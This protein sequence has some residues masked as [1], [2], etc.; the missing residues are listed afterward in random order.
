M[1][2]P[3][4]AL[5]L[6]PRANLEQYKKRSKDLVKAANSTN[7]SALRE[8]ARSWVESLMKLAKLK[9]TPQLPVGVEAWIDQLE[10]F[11]REEK[12]ATRFS[13][14]KAQFV[15]ARAHG[16]ESWPKLAHHIESLA[17][18]NSA[19]S[20][21]E[22]AAEAIVAG[23]LESLKKL[24]ERN[25]EMA[26]AR[27]G[28]RHRATLLH[29]V[30][31]NGVEGYR[32]KTPKN[33]VQIA[34][35]LLEAGA[36]VNAAAEVY[37][38]KATT[39]ALVATSVHPEQAGLQESLMELLLGR[40]ASIEPG[41]VAACLANGRLRAA[42]FLARAGAELDLESAAGLGEMEVVRSFFDKR[43][44]LSSKAKPLQM[45]RGLWWASEYGHPEVVELLIERGA[46]MDEPS[47]DGQTALHW[48]VIGG[49]VEI[50][51]LLLARGASFE[52]RNSYGGTPLGQ[53]RWSEKNGPRGVDYARV[54]AVLLQAGAKD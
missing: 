35:L 24:L 46:R 41:L 53:A 18:K 42:E 54:I 32:Q 49:Q 50:V 38:G 7:P 12:S 25:R 23:D 34:E 13:L 37:G 30:S 51:R 9:I 40:G 15:L 44:N 20:D 29:Y 48:A 2:P 11:A 47:R 6:P 26:R 31:A 36:E 8:W 19:T 52:V 39:L 10:K 3:Q 21:F 27:S 16:F 45:Q 22:R 33:A 28:R 4:D 17:G 14:A 43:G 1:F 5:P